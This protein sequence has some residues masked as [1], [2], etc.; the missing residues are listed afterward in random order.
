M[1]AEEMC[2]SICNAF[3]AIVASIDDVRQREHSKIQEHVQ[4]QMQ[5]NEAKMQKLLH[6]KQ[7]EV[8]EMLQAGRRQCEE[9]ISRAIGECDACYKA[10]LKLSRDTFDSEAHEL[11]LSVGLL[12]AQASEART[13]YAVLV[14]QQQQQQQTLQALKSRC[15]ALTTAL[16]AKDKQLQDYTLAANIQKI[17]QTLSAT[18]LSNTSGAEQNSSPRSPEKKDGGDRGV[19]AEQ[20]CATPNADGGRVG[21]ISSDEALA[22]SA[23]Y[24]TE[25]TSVRWEERLKRL[26]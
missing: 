20:A 9:D 10:D 14:K 8:Q 6:D 4:Q 3:T 2:A 1:S 19:G 16:V 25:V 11:K 21:R 23:K 18:S 22:L 5:K 7:D 17:S 12:K 24:E 13:A 26:F 15:A